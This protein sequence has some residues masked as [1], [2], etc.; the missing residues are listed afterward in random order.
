M[1]LFSI[2]WFFQT[3]VLTSIMIAFVAWCHLGVIA[4]AVLFGLA[5]MAYKGPV[6]T[7]SPL[8]RIL[9][10]TSLVAVIHGAI[11]GARHG[12]VW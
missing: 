4:L 9:C 11:V 1:T 5:G 10:I 12:R 7:F 3:G 8:F 6:E 2:M